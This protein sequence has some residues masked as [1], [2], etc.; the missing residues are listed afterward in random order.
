MKQSLTWKLTLSAALLSGTA[1]LAQEDRTVRIVL[2]EEL[3]VVE[4]CMA[5]RSDVGRVILQNVNETLTEFDPGTSTLKPRLATEWTQVDDDTWRIKLRDGVTFHDGTTLDAADIAFT[6]DRIKVPE[7]GCEV[8]VKYFGDIEFADRGRRRPDHRGHHHARLADPAA[9]ALDRADRAVRDPGRRVR[10]P[11]RS[12]P[13]P[14]SS[15]SGTPARTS[16]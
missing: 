6:L 5:A 2:N 12:A 11:S 10:R 4:P 8:G 9:P 7:F 14:T 15:T 1:A 16:S 3:D 13:A